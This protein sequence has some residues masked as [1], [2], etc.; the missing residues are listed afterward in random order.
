MQNIYMIFEYIYIQKD[1][2]NYD[3]FSIEKIFKIIDFL[4]RIIENLFN[5]SLEEKN[6]LD[7]NMLDII[8]EKYLNTTLNGLLQNNIEILLYKNIFLNLDDYKIYNYIFINIY[9]NIGLFLENII[10]FLDKLYIELI[11]NTYIKI[12][13]RYWI[14]YSM[15]YDIYDIHN[16]NFNIF[17]DKYYSNSIELISDLKKKYNLNVLYNLN[18]IELLNDLRIKHDFFYEKKKYINK[19][20]LYN[21][22]TF[23]LLYDIDIL[24]FKNNYIKHII[25]NQNIEFIRKNYL[26]L[27]NFK[28]NTETNSLLLKNKILKINEDIYNENKY[29][30]WFYKKYNDNKL[31]IGRNIVLWYAKDHWIFGMPKKIIDIESITNEDLFKY[32]GGYTFWHVLN[33]NFYKNNYDLSIH[34]SHNLQIWYSY[35]WKF[36]TGY[37]WDN[38]H[39][40]FYKKKF[41]PKRLPQLWRIEYA[42]WKFR[43]VRIDYI[44][45]THGTY[46]KNLFKNYVISEDIW[47]TKKI[48]LQKKKKFTTRFNQNWWLLKEILTRTPK[49]KESNLNKELFYNEFFKKKRILSKHKTLKKNLLLIIKI[50]EYFRKENPNKW[51]FR[52]ILKFSDEN[53]LLLNKTKKYSENIKMLIQSLWIKEYTKNIIYNTSKKYVF[54]SLDKIIEKENYT[55]IKD[56]NNM[57]INQIKKKSIIDVKR[58]ILDFELKKKKIIHIKKYFWELF[59]SEENKEKL[60]IFYKKHYTKRKSCVHPDRLTLGTSVFFNDK[61][62][63]IFYIQGSNISFLDKLIYSYH[64]YNLE[65]FGRNWRDEFVPIVYERDIW[66]LIFDFIYFQNSVVDFMNITN[67]R[68]TARGYGVFWRI[69]YRYDVWGDTYWFSIPWIKFKMNPFIFIWNDVFY[70]FDL[71]EETK[72]DIIKKEYWQN[73]ANVYENEKKYYENYIFIKNRKMLLYNYINNIYIIYNYIITFIIFN[74]KVYMYIIKKLTINNKL[75]WLIIILL[76]YLIINILIILLIKSSIP[77]NNIYGLKI[78]KKTNFYAKELK[79]FIENDKYFF[80]KIFNIEQKF[81]YSLSL[82]KDLGNNN[83]SWIKKKI[84]NKYSNYIK[85]KLKKKY[86][87]FYKNL[88]FEE[89]M[90]K[91]F[92][93]KKYML[94]IGTW[95]YSFIFFR[96]NSLSIVLLKIFDKLLNIRFYNLNRILSKENIKLYHELLRIYVKTPE[97]VTFKKFAFYFKLIFG[98]IWIIVYTEILNIVYFIYTG[99][100]DRYVVGLQSALT[101]QRKERTEKILQEIVD[102]M[103]NLKKDKTIEWYQEHIDYIL[104]TVDK[105]NNIIFSNTIYDDNYEDFNYKIELY[106]MEKRKELNFNKL[107]LELIFII[108]IKTIENT[109]D[110]L[111]LLYLLKLKKNYEIQEIKTLDDIKI[112]LFNKDTELQQFKLKSINYLLFEVLLKNVKNPELKK[113]YLN[114]LNIEENI[115][116]NIDWYEKYWNILKHQNLDENNLDKEINKKLLTTF[117][118]YRWYSFIGDRVYYYI[119][120]F[121]IIISVWFN[122]IK[123][124][125]YNE[126]SL[127]TIFI[128]FYNDLKNFIRKTYWEYLI[129]TYNSEKKIKISVINI[130]KFS[131]WLIPILISIKLLIILYLIYHIVYK[132]V[133]KI[134]KIKNKLNYKLSNKKIKKLFNFF[135]LLFK[136]IFLDLKTKKSIIKILYINIY[137]LISKLEILIYLIKKKDYKNLKIW[138]KLNYILITEII[139]IWF[140]KINKK[141]KLSSLTSKK[142]ALIWL[143]LKYNK[144]MKDFR[145]GIKEFI[146]NII[147]LLVN[148]YIIINL[149]E[150]VFMSLWYD[151]NTLTKGVFTDNIIKIIIKDFKKNKSIFLSIKILN[152]YIYLIYKKIYFNY[153]NQDWRDKKVKFKFSQNLEKIIDWGEISSAIWIETSNTW[154]FEN[155]LEKKA[156]DYKKKEAAKESFDD[157][158]NKSGLEINWENVYMLYLNFKN[159][160]VN[161][162]YEIMYD[163]EK[164]YRNLGKT[165]G[166]KHLTPIK[167]LKLSYKILKQKKKIW[168]I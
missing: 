145:I 33:N 54:F 23:G 25:R 77:K 26:D 58:E 131:I 81:I 114:K 89:N 163:L 99:W 20:P 96:N 94:S 113:E 103:D 74:I 132:Q 101:N 149:E 66:L 87:I 67:A 49:M 42:I 83:T 59:F 104:K 3:I 15:L 129:L 4:N 2:L 138:L 45:N 127:K 82:S 34:K 165:L 47:D 28:E 88:I 84:Y 57:I 21:Y 135:I 142:F 24:T 69:H 8:N 105:K 144:L 31:K 134:I 64:L 11:N 46:I 38:Y 7:K 72:K 90:E 5:I 118:L 156:N 53:W 122:S 1:I 168:K 51:H 63:I 18:S 143:L 148:K 37:V 153:L 130:L 62:L 124:V 112:L 14:N 55:L 44:K 75:F 85:E 95:F 50:E 147:Y 139:K 30:F 65:F 154:I 19:I 48:I 9:K 70:K 60:N 116:E 136:M 128:I 117:I 159:Y 39:K 40:T 157:E 150:N 12:Y 155:Y 79:D 106:L 158:E 167:K 98:S 152:K 52:K 32:F 141:K 146:T 17:S 161:Y 36:L 10:F 133:I 78:L 80:S 119:H 100:Y 109:K 6:I 76:I 91:I 137:N 111:N 108:D 162:L 151:I 110:I 125:K 126:N 166:T 35:T 97:F 164:T 160:F 73:L 13:W 140:L 123:K 56:K 27:I 22:S 29:Y 102:L 43:E 107:F 121:N 41:W 86:D 71:F 115:E 120:V 93:N 61:A 68:A 92:N 16:Y